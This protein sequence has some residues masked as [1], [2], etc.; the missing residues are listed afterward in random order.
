MLES[1]LNFIKKYCSMMVVRQLANTKYSDKYAIIIIW[2]SLNFDVFSIALTLFLTLFISSFLTW[3]RWTLIVI[4]KC[5]YYEIIIQFVIFCLFGQLQ[6]L[7][8]F[9]WIDGLMKCVHVHFLSL[10]LSSIISL[11]LKQSTE[12]LKDQFPK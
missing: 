1:Y 7:A 3:K 11:L 2:P 4:M 10:F 8:I 6:P 9:Y 12:Q 5:Y